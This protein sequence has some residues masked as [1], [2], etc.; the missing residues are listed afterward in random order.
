VLHRDI[1]PTNVGYSTSGVPKLLDFGL[2]K[3]LDDSRTAA[4]VLEIR[5][6]DL[7]DVP[8][9]ALTELTV[10][11]RLVGTPIYLSP[12][13]AH[14][15]DPSPSFDLWALSVTLFEAIAGTHPLRIQDTKGLRGRIFDGDVAD[16]EDVWPESPEPLRR[17]FADAL[18]REPRRRPKS[19]LELRDAL[20]GLR[21]ELAR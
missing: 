9:Q 2:A 16:I 5:Y 11:R 10:T 6:D 21:E 4:S 13:A 14:G 8:I 12:E 7:D 20:V 17:F 19:A 1:K 18:A 3:I 15:A